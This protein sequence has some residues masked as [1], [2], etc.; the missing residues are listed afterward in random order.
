MKAKGSYSLKRHLN[1]PMLSFGRMG[2]TGRAKAPCTLGPCA[3]LANSETAK[4]RGQGP[5]SSKKNTAIS[6]SASA[7][8]GAA[9]TADLSASSS[10]IGAY[11]WLD[12]SDRRRCWLTVCHGAA[13]LS[14]GPGKVVSDASMI[15]DARG[16]NDSKAMHFNNA[17]EGEA[18]AP[19]VTK[20][21]E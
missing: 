12:N 8:R 3:T 21:H 2:F 4:R 1:F 17:D 11:P 5:H 18:K 15:H 10:G 16:A 14:S 7:L 19:V 9:N 13:L 20:H 6:T